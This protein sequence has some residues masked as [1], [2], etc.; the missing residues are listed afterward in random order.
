MQ[1]LFQKQNANLLTPK[2]V[3]SRAWVWGRSLAGTTGSNLAG[4]M[5][6]CLLRVLCDVK[7][8]SL[9]RADHSSREVLSPTEYGVSEWV[10]SRNVI[11]QSQAH[12]GFRAMKKKSKFNMVLAM[13]AQAGVEVCEFFSLVNKSPQQM[14]LINQ[15]YSPSLYHERSATFTQFTGGLVNLRAGLSI[16]ENIRMFLPHWISNYFSLVVKP[17]IQNK[18]FCFQDYQTEDS[19]SISYFILR[20]DE[21]RGPLLAL[22]LA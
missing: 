21:N 1:T 3:S 20:N 19:K 9:R 7:Q 18:P 8:T 14:E 13:K 6:V 12:Q 2:A 15:L 16:L 17:T 5:S 4:N 11:Q 22:V 10:W